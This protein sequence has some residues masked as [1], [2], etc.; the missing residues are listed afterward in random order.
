MA[1]ND[2]RAIVLDCLKRVAPEA[3]F[4]HIDAHRSFYEQM[5]FDSVDYLNFVL[6]MEN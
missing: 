1:A 2:L 6:A 4:D 3:D 5:D